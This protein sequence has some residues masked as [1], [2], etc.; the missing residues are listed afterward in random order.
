M[1]MANP[2][3]SPRSFCGGKRKC[4][5]RTASLLFFVWLCTAGSLFANATVT[6]VSLQSPRLSQAGVTNLFSPIHVEATADDT[7]TVSGYAVYVDNQNVYQNFK[8]SVDAWI[9]IPRGYHTLYVKA[10]DAAGNLNTATYE[11]N[12]TG[13]APPVPPVRAHR[14]LN[15]DNATW[16][17]DNNPDVGGSCNH[18]SFG[19]FSGTSDPNTQ[20]APAF[21]GAGKHFILTSG[22]TYD[23]SLFYWKYT[24][25]SLNLAGDTNFLWDFWFYVPEATTWSTVQAL[26]FDLF[27]AVQLSDGVHEFMFGS[28]CNYVTNQWQFWLPQGNGLNWTNSSISPCRFSTRQWHHAT[29]FLQRVKP[30]GFQQIP[31]TFSSTSDKNTSLRFGTLTIDGQTEYLG[32]VAW[33]T[34]PSPAWSPVLGVQH[35]LD[36]VVAGAV[37]EEF[38][39]RES[40]TSW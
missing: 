25:T 6:S 38:T 4:S 22:C 19:A 7:A 21:D 15:I 20:N 8:P 36:S 31:K 37:I 28:Q 40:L 33:S 23:D 10:S 16:T 3:S 5:G 29:Y 18:G 39:D 30:S 34:I 12:I 9:A 32:G 26:E 17:V 2:Y 24:S 27:Q 11:I 35:Q 14:F 13:F 1:F